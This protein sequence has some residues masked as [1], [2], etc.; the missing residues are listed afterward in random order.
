MHKDDIAV[1]GIVYYSRLYLAARHTRPVTGVNAASD[2]RHIG[3]E[4]ENVGVVRKVWRTVKIGRFSCYIIDKIIANDQI[5]ED[6]D[7]STNI[8]NRIIYNNHI[9]ILAIHKIMV[10][11]KLNI[12]VFYGEG[13]KIKIQKTLFF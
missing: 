11:K 9:F 2:C 10:L 3:E 1:F 4:R 5:T 7:E 13:L 6:I 8:P 12:K